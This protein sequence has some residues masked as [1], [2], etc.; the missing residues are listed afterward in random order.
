VRGA[1]CDELASREQVE[2][3]E[4]GSKDSQCVTLTEGRRGAG[5]LVLQGG[6]T[7]GRSEGKAFGTCEP[8]ATGFWTLMLLL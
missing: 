4:C 6:K 1:R 2:R 8:A 7:R 5:R 3:E